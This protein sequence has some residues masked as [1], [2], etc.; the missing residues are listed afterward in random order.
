MTLD[1][2]TG[3]I[4]LGICERGYV[5]VLPRITVRHIQ[6]VVAA[7]YGIPVAEMISHR[8]ARHVARPR[9]VA[10]FMTREL[11]P[12]SLPNIGRM[13]GDRDHTTVMHAIAKVESLIASG[14]DFAVDV[15]TIR[16]HLTESTTY[17]QPH[18]RY[19]QDFAFRTMRKSHFCGREQIVKTQEQR[20]A[21]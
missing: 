2:P 13:F 5:F 18:P 9:Q 19:S 8:R 11:T 6:N 15:E 20:V 14:A 12:Q 10:I 4:R 21:A 3:D 1:I 16:S 17:A 7:F